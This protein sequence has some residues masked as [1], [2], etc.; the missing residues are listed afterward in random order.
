MVVWLVGTV[1]IFVQINMGLDAKFFDT[2]CFNISIGGFGLKRT[3][4]FNLSKD[5]V[6][7]MCIG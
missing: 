7:I 1:Y 2:G 5:K 3:M 6:K 4:L